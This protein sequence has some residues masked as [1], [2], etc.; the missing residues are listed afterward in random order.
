MTGKMIRKKTRTNRRS[1]FITMEMLLSSLL[2]ATFSAAQQP[3]TDPAPEGND[4]ILGPQLIAWSELQKP[5]PVSPPAQAQTHASQ[6]DARR[7]T[8][9]TVTG[10]VA[11]V[12]KGY[13]LETG[14][15]LTHQLDAQDKAMPYEGKRV[16]VEGILDPTTNLIQVHSIQP[17]G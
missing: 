9:R 2:L 6:S 4:G 8:A 16:R 3:P 7:Q 12:E 11:K 10:V 15:S 17:I 5:Q 13:V 14:D 1:V